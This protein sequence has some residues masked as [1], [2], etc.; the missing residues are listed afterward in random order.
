MVEGHELETRRNLLAAQ[1]RT[2]ERTG[3]AFDEL[4]E[5]GVVGGSGGAK[6]Y[7]HVQ[8]VI[9]SRCQMVEGADSAGRFRNRTRGMPS[10]ANPS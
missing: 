4:L 5:L 1:E 3:R 2:Q 9:R 10:T 6:T 7:S 8:A